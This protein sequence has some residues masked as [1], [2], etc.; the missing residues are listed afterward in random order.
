MTESYKSEF[1]EVSSPQ[2]YVTRCIKQPFTR[3]SENYTIDPG[4]VTK[5]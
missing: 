2:H 5:K 1:K 4:Q 3:E